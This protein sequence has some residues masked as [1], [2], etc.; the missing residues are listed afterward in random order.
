MNDIKFAKLHAGEKPMRILIIGKP[1]TGKSQMAERVSKDYRL[2]I[3]D[4]IPTLDNIPDEK[5]YIC[6]QLY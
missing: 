3:I 6:P 1:G 2:P 5:G 4:E